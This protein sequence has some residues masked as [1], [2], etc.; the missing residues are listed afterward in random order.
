MQSSPTPGNQHTFLGLMILY[1]Y[2]LLLETSATHCLISQQSVGWWPSSLGVS[3]DA[4]SI[5]LYPSLP[6]PSVKPLRLPVRATRISDQ[7]LLSQQQLCFRLLEGLCVLPTPHA[8]TGHLATSTSSSCL[9]HHPTPKM[10]SLRPSIPPRGSLA[11]PAPI[12]AE[13]PVWSFAPEGCAPA[14]PSLKDLVH[15]GSL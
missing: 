11:A 9:I 2:K 6:E 10:R 7:H 5:T 4:S 14:V 12:E 8:P 13:P 3:G 1:M 15:R